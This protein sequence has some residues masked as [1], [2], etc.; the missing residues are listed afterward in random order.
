MHRGGRTHTQITH[1]HTNH[2]RLVHVMHF[3]IK[4]ACRRAKLTNYTQQIKTH[5]TLTRILEFRYL[6]VQK[7]K[8][9]WVKFEFVH[10]NLSFWSWLVWGVKY[11]E[12][13]LWIPYDMMICMIICTM[14]WSYVL[15]WSML[16]GIQYDH[17][18]W[19]SEAS[20]YAAYTV[21]TLYMQQYI[22]DLHITMCIRCMRHMH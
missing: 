8:K 20:G 6:A 2:S 14:I 22:Y 3:G 11:V 17:M 10:R 13:N 21:Y 5:H 7:S 18:Y 15:G 4:Y 19:E 16:S 1:T 12:W 9:N